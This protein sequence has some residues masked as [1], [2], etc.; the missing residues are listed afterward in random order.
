MGQWKV[1]FVHDSIFGDKKG[2]MQICYS[3][4]QCMKKVDA[5]MHLKLKHIQ[6]ST[7]A[8]YCYH[9]WFLLTIQC[10]HIS[11]R[12]GLGEEGIQMR[13][14]IVWLSESA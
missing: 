10:M 12:Q 7:R 14:A 4:S 6:N 8:A 1:V 11:C 9:S 3:Y 5:Q 2:I 13:Y